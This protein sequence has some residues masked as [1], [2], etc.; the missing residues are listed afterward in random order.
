MSVSVCVFVSLS[1]CVY[2]CL[3]VIIFSELH[4]RSLPI[5]FIHVSYSRGSII[6]WRCTDMLCIS[7]SMDD[8]I[9]AQKQKLTLLEI[10]AR[11]RQ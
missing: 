11:L 1:L 3:T 4:V 7:D 2:V 9:F 5:F 8:V 6:L 10:A